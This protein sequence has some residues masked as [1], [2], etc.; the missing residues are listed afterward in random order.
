MDLNPWIL[1]S[2]ICENGFWLKLIIGSLA[3]NTFCRIHFEHFH[4]L[5]FLLKMGLCQWVCIPCRFGWG[6]CDDFQILFGIRNANACLSEWDSMTKLTLVLQERLPGKSNTEL[7][8]NI[9]EIYYSWLT[10]DTLATSHRLSFTVITYTLSSD[11][12]LKFD[13]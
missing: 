5:F 13:Q 7:E 12:H 2:W 4:I 3:F 11:I 6:S 9:W 8:T 10:I 1:Y